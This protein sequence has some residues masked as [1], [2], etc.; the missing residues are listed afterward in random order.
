MLECADLCS[1]SGQANW[2]EGEVVFFPFYLLI[3]LCS[4]RRR[5]LQL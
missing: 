5:Q 2:Y 1:S 3:E 4:D